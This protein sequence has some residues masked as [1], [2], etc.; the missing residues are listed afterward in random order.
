V[1]AAWLNVRTNAKSVK[2]QRAIGA[3]LQEGAKLEQDSAAKEE[4]ILKIVASRL[5]S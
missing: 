1:R 3:I 4:E 5:E 2:D